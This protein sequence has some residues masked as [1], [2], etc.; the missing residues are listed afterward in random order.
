MLFIERKVALS[1]LTEKERMSFLHCFCCDGIFHLLGKEKVPAV[2]KAVQVRL[3]DLYSY[4][5]A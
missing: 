1:Q 5:D 2:K 4:S 3:F